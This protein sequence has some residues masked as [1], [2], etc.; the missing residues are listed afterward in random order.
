MARLFNFLLYIKRKIY[1]YPMQGN[2][3]LHPIRE[4]GVCCYHTFLTRE[5]RFFVK[6]NINL[7]PM[8]GNVTL[9]PIRESGVCCYHTFL[10]REK[11]FFVKRNI[12]SYP[13]Q[14]C[15]DDVLNRFCNRGL[16][17]E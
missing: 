7:Y 11:R 13:M 17:R 16:I 5:K 6:R 2:V 12:N 1:L 3:T 9:H 10:T 14:G 4:S 8:Q 15:T